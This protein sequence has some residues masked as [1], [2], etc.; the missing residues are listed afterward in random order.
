MPAVD[1]VPPTTLAFWGFKASGDITQE[2]KKKWKAS[3]W[4]TRGLKAEILLGEAVRTIEES[5]ESYGS[6]EPQPVTVTGD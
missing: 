4:K 3:C 5:S 6:K 2:Q 1:T